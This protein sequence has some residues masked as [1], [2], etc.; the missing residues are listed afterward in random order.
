MTSSTEPAAPTTPAVPVQ[1]TFDAADPHRIARFWAQALRYENEDNSLIVRQLLEAGQLPD[2][3]VVETETGLG[4]RDLAA[5]RD[6]AGAGP[7]LLFQRVPEPKTVKNRVHLDLHVGP[8]RLEAEVDRLEGL[9]AER[10]WTSHDRGPLTI[11]M[12]D[13]E[14]NE[15]CLA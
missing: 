1:V 9:G 6:P 10:A 14:G 3:A 12:R 8:E 15:L 4:F 2:E 11:T 7:R 13:P 5:C